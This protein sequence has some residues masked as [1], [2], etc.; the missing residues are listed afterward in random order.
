[1]K[2]YIGKDDLPLI[3][4]ILERGADVRI[5]KSDKGISIVSEDAK[6]MSR[7]KLE[8]LPEQ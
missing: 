3:N 2:E 6:V 8:D 4:F 5:R 1:M 7:K